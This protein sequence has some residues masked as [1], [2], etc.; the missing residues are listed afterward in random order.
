M[1]SRLCC[2]G[3]GSFFNLS[4]NRDSV[5]CPAQFV[6]AAHPLGVGVWGEQITACTLS[7]LL[8]GEQEKSFSLLGSFCKGDDTP[9]AFT[10]LESPTGNSHAGYDLHKKC[11]HLIHDVSERN[12]V[13]I[14]TKSSAWYLITW[15]IPFHVSEALPRPGD[16]MSSFGAI[17]DDALSD[18]WGYL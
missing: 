15:L 8:Q 7:S 12:A 13:Q 10:A 14:V 2:W 4:M 3:W 16:V 6:S 1:W 18:W 5:A 11:S 9:E 17:L